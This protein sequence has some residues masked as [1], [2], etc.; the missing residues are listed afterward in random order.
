MCFAKNA[1]KIYAAALTCLHADG[2]ALAAQW[3][4]VPAFN[5]TSVEA[6]RRASVRDGNMR[7]KVNKEK[8]SGTTGN[9]FEVFRS[10]HSLQSANSC[11]YAIHVDTTRLDLWC[12]H[13]LSTFPPILLLRATATQT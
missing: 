10:S 2:A 7:F 8:T 5:R 13:I 12:Y 4:D 6:F 9:P 3:Q 11:E 1:T